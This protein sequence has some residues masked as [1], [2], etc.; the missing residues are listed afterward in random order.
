MSGVDITPVFGGGGFFRVIVTPPN[1]IARDV[2]FFRDAPVQINSMSTVDPFGAA[3]AQV[4]FPAITFLDRGGSGDLDWLIPNS[5]IDIVYYDSET[6]RPTQWAWEGFI[7]SEE[8]EAE[9]RTVTCKGALFQL[10]NFLAYPTYPQQPI[11]YE[12]LIK[13]SFDPQ[14]NP[15]LRTKP[16]KI[17]YPDDWTTLVPSYTA[18]TP[19]YLRPWGVKA[20]EKWT[21]LT[22]R[23][24]GTWE[25]RLT[26]HIQTLLSVMYT[27][28]GGQWTVRH[29]YGRQPVLQVRPALRYPTSDTLVVN[30]GAHGVDVRVSRDFTQSTNVVYAQGQDL[31]GTTYSGMQ[32]TSDGK[33]TFFEPFSALPQVYPAADTNPRLLPYM[34]RKESMLQIPQGID[35]I[36]AREIATN[37]IRKHADPGFTGSITL[38]TDPL[39]NDKPFS[40]L[41]VRA[42]DTILVK[43][44]L[45]TDILFH[46]S[47]ATVN[48]EDETVSLTVDSKFRD[49]L[50]VAEVAARTRDALDPVR[51]LQTGRYSVTIQDLIKPWS[52]S[53]GSGVIPSGG[54]QDATELFNKLMPTSAQFPWEEWTKKYPPAKYPQYYIK[55]DRKKANA[56]QNWSGVA[57]DGIAV[58]SIPV[59]MSQAGTIRL[60]QIAAYDLSGNV[61]PVRFHVG[62]YGNSGVNPQSMPMLPQAWLNTKEGQATGYKAGERY[63][64]FPD[65]F[66]SQLAD[67]SEQGN[68]NYL[69]AGQAD[70]A[71]A[72]GNYYEPAGYSPGLKSRGAPKS[73]KLVDESSWSFDTSTQTGF[74]KYNVKNTQKNPTVGMMYIMI[75][76]DDHG[77]SGPVFFLGRLFRQ[78]PTG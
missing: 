48:V 17:V 70:Q 25:P 66:E 56:T 55:I 11:P 12:L 20:G 35:E 21:G 2:T 54:K 23:S 3:S 31:A 41:L 74:D 4:T 44:L 59:K 22:T 68:A 53:D 65:A 32:V 63:P 75:Y 13:Q 36:S 16:L 76:C 7:V 24:S 42:G 73:G 69:L 30:A 5:N 50:T 38:T 72:W 37:Q 71:I 34:M 61:M 26:G 43:G 19:W 46:I 14:L 18:D 62:I 58:A 64:F 6:R 51:L 1:G 28:A 39:R 78:E 47:Q 57:R 60:S 9:G 8:I 77:I 27:D 45:G 49:A 33:T 29:N 52:Y 15:S 40:R 67:G 10:D